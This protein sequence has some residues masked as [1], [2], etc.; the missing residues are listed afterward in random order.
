[1]I[2]IIEKFFN[3]ILFNNRNKVINLQKLVINLEKLIK[4]Y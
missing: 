2:E 4:T 1:M 3:Q